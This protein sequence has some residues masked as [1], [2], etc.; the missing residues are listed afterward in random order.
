M[1]QSGTVHRIGPKVRRINPG[2]RN[3]INLVDLLDL[4]NNASLTIASFRRK[5]GQLAFPFPEPKDVTNILRRLAE[6]E[7]LIDIVSSPPDEKSAHY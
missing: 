7:D 4:V 3:A 2:D 5:N 6:M 1:Q